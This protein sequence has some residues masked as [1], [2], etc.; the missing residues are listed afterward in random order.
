MIKWPVNLN[1]I[2]RLQIEI[3]SIC[4]AKCPSCER[5]N[6][7][8]F[9]NDV[10]KKSLIEKNRITIDQFKK[11]FDYD[12]KSLESI[13]LCGNVDEPTLNPD[14][15]KI[16]EFISN[17]FPNIHCNISTNG[18]T[19]NDFFWKELAKIKKVNVI[20]GI[21]GL[22]DTNHIYRRNVKWKK[23]EKN[24]RT[25]ISEG[26]LAVWQFIVFEH[27]KHQLEL[28]KK[29]SKDE[30]FAMFLTKYSGRQND[31]AIKAIQV[32]KEAKKIIKC[33]ATYN[34]KEL[35]K[36]FFVDAVGN[37]FPCCWMGTANHRRD[38]YEKISKKFYGPLSNNLKYISLEEIVS[39][40]LFAHTFEN[41]DKLSVCNLMCKN[42]ETDFDLHDIDNPI[43]KKEVEERS[44]RFI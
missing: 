37:V 32:K 1:D 28:A 13:H 25:F 18:G 33:K 2:T 19:K 15:L 41:F 5:N 3:T 7:Y 10:Y 6:Y 35:E 4:N 44:R 12:F 20:F 43:I 8:E 9:E 34:S 14:L 36:S 42:D 40:D 11:W 26:G 27:N 39:G 38:F 21:D 16:C 17:R 24:F 29:I 23:L 31:D 30:G 22:E